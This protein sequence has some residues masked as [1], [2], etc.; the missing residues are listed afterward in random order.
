MS[1]LGKS[2]S[3]VI[4][5]IFFED[6][7]MTGLKKINEDLEQGKVHLQ[8][9]LKKSDKEISKVKQATE[10]IKEKQVI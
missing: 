2:F 5:E 4:F 9:L 8:E 6:A 10:V 7:E 3:S 1:Q